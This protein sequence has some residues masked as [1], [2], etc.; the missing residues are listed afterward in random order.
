MPNLR[1]SKLM[2][3]PTTMRSNSICLNSPTNVCSLLKDASMLSRGSTEEGTLTSMLVQYKSLHLPIS[4]LISAIL[5]MQRRIRKLEL[6]WRTI[7]S[8][9]LSRRNSLVM[10]FITLKG[11]IKSHLLWFWGMLLSMRNL[12]VRFRT[13]SI[14][15]LQSKSSSSYYQNTN[16]QASLSPSPTAQF[17]SSPPRRTTKARWSSLVSLCAKPPSKVP[18]FSPTP[19]KCLFLA[20]T[21][22]SSTT[23]TSATST[24]KQ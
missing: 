10:G 21:P 14:M 6:I 22:S 13:L 16:T 2:S 8:M 17:T 11:R 4:H 7:I 18:P 23:A 5:C 24:V 1:T 20:L 19:A 3:R 9:I 12:W 15:S